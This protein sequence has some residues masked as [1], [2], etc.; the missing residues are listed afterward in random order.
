MSQ[1]RCVVDSRDTLGEGPIWSPRDGRVFWFDIKGKKLRWFS[2]EDGG[3]GAWD[4]PIRCSAAAPRESGGLIVACEAGLAGFDLSQG[5]LTVIN[6]V[7][8]PEGF[9]SNDGKIDVAGRFWWSSMD[10]DHGNRPGDFY[11]TTPDGFTE[12]VLEGIHIPNTISCSP[13]GDRLYVADSKLQTIFVHDMDPKT[14]ALSNRREFAST[15]G[16]A[17]A[18]DGSAVDAEGYLWNAQWGASRIVRYAPDGRV[19]RIIETPVEQP[20]SC[21]F[22][23]PDLATLY[24]TT[25]REYLTDADLER[26]PQAGGLFAFEPGVKGLALPSFAA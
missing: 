5:A 1:L 3:D 23:G 12:K 25:A 21:A 13:A 2:P 16:E 15:K 8:L 14:G 6:K 26:Q 17:G 19:D 18:P 24:V 10:D 9:R 20:S 11:C 22:G 4:L 7:P